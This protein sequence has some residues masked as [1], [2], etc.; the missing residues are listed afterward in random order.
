MFKSIQFLELQERRN[1]I[2]FIG[3]SS[4]DQVT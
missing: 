2:G 3:P 1:S 4:V